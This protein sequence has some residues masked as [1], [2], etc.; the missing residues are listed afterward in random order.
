[1]SEFD[2]IKRYFTRPTPNSIL[3]VGDDAALLSVSAG[4]E[5]AISTDMLVSGTHFFSDA[6][7][8][9]LGHK[10]LAVNLSDLAAMGATPRWATLALSLPSIDELWLQKFSQ[11][12]FS[13]A[14][15]YGVELIGGDTTRGPLNLSVT[16]L[17]EV[18]SGEA[19]RRD[20]AQVNDDIW[21]SGTL[22]EAALTL[23]HLQERIELPQAMLEICAPR[24]HQ[25]QPRVELGL[26]LRGIANSA[27]DVSDGL[28]ADLGH[29]LVRSKLGAEIKFEEIPSFLRRGESNVIKALD[30][31]LPAG[32]FILSLS[33]GG[34]EPPSVKLFERCVLAGGDDYELCFT[35]SALRRT[36]IEKISN[37]L[38]LPLTRIGKTKAGNGCVVLAEDGSQIKIEGAG[39]D[40]FA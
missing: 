17:G 8:Y 10:T 33:K 21:V 26:A 32:Q 35:A 9:G 5:L 40:H 2:L 13:L 24:L 20:G 15:K 1:M 25:P 3:G 23:A 28:L 19:L 30:S 27:I 39:Y 29:I 11:G 31:R 12:F 14:D 22:G 34:N 38:A 18:P 37:T 6:D 7:P 36:E 16:I 4:M